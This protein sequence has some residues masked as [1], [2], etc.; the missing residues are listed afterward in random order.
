MILQTTPSQF[1]EALLYKKFIRYYLQQS[2][3]Q[4]FFLRNNSCYLFALQLPI[5]TIPSPFLLTIKN[6]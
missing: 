5:P 6:S 4:K 2:G 3:K 1:L